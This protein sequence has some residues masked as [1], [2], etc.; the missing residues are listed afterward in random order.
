MNKIAVAILA[1]TL[2]ACGGGGGDSSESTNTPIIEETP[3][4]P[5]EVMPIGLWEGS[6][7]SDGI[8]FHTFGLV[9]PDGEA[10]YISDD[11]EQDKALLT[12]S[13]SDFSGDIVGYDLTGLLI[14]SGTIAGSYSSSL[15]SGTTTVDGIEVSTF[16][17]ELS[18]QSSEGASFDIIKGNYSS[19]N[20]ET[21]MAI[22]VDGLLS[23]SDTNGCQYSGNITIPDS[24]VNVYKLALTVSSCG[25]LNS[26]YTGLAT[27]AEL[28]GDEPQ[29][30]LLFLVDNDVNA[31]TNFIVK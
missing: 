23:G 5:A 26:T 2:T 9:A 10:R 6:V 13:G 4:T 22:D 19:F 24:S 12:L 7:V 17:L 27:Y 20:A 1:S 21:S 30:G 14:A 8:T 18:D 11:G 15:I 3:S 16:S 28:F 25:D 29:K 31:V